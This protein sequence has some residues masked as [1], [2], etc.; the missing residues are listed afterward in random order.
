METELTRSVRRVTT[1]L[2][3]ARF[4]TMT[5]GNILLTV[6]ASCWRTLGL[7]EFH[8]Y[9]RFSSSEEERVW[10]FHPTHGAGN[11][12]TCISMAD[13]AMSGWGQAIGVGAG[14][15]QLHHTHWPPKE[16]RCR[17]GRVPCTRL[18]R[19]DGLNVI[20]GLRTFLDPSLVYSPNTGSFLSQLMFGWYIGKVLDG[21]S[22]H[23]FC[24]PSSPRSVTVSGML[25][26]A[27]SRS[28]AVVIQGFRMGNT[29]RSVSGNDAC[30]V[31][32]KIAELSVNHL[33]SKY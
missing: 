25:V 8:E 4:P 27:S 20:M 12:P 22:S 2:S 28:R 1:F 9:W 7:E 29:S 3:T 23:D 17:K 13:K 16:S 14:H 5:A 19:G 33:F 30:T 15:L 26:L 11:T 10:E 6:G 32:R 24:H 18:K 31:V 21:G